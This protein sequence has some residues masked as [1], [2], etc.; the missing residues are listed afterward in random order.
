MTAALLEEDL[1]L[2]RRFFVWL[3]K[4]TYNEKRT[5]GWGPVLPAWPGFAIDAA[6]WGGAV[7]LTLAA[8]GVLRRL[9][10]P[11][12]RCLAC[13]YDL[14][15]T[16][17]GVC[18][19]CGRKVNH[20]PLRAK[21]GGQGAVGYRGCGDGAMASRRRAARLIGMG[22]VCCAIGA[23]VTVGVAWACALRP[24]PDGETRRSFAFQEGTTWYRCVE[25]EVWWMTMQ[26]V[27]TAEH[28]APGSGTV[29]IRTA[30]G[31][32]DERLPIGQR[33]RGARLPI[34]GNV[35]DD[36]HL[37]WPARA[38]WGGEDSNWYADM[39]NIL[40]WPK[41]IAVKKTSDQKYWW[42]GDGR[43]R[44]PYGVLFAGFLLD[45]AF[46]GAAPLGLGLGVGCWRRRSRRRRGRC[47]ACGYD[48][49]GV[50]AGVCPECGAEF[51]RPPGDRAK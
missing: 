46:Y 48:L 20:A 28:A 45:T 7:Y 13:G 40:G 6:F 15:G 21:K 29:L 27:Q 44:L 49:A 2:T 30:G 11:A 22:V 34:H 19:E 37:G 47:V 24:W 5:R 43:F 41:T 38:L 42:A 33:P 50:G 9:L 17:G 25:T 12:G 23:V 3:P 16:Q 35:T 32:R 51:A 8:S 26:Y 36:R 14:S 4:W 1:K 10:R 39:G 18:P 31:F